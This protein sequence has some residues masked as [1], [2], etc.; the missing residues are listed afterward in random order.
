MAGQELEA[1]RKKGRRSRRRSAGGNVRRMLGMLALMGDSGP[2]RAAAQ[3]DHLEAGRLFERG[4]EVGEPDAADDVP[5]AP[6]VPG[7]NVRW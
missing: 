4:W 2:L 6:A 3:G 1:G 7:P 5:E